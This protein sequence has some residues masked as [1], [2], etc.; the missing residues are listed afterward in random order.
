MEDRALTGYPSVD[1]PWL[2]Y[3]SEEQKNA[4]PPEPM[5]IYACLRQMAESYG[6][7]TAIRFDGMPISYD[8]L[9]A[10]I[11][12]TADALLSA[13]IGEDDIVLAD[14]PTIPQE[15]YLL[16]ACSKIGACI[17]YALP[18]SSPQRLCASANT[19]SS[20]ILFTCDMPPESRAYI[21]SHSCVRQI[22]SLSADRAGDGWAAFLD[23]ADRHAALTRK[24]SRK[25]FYICQTGGSTG[26]PKAVM[27]SNYAF[28]H[29]MFE[30]LTSSGYLDR[31]SSWMPLWPLFSVS[32]AISCCHVPL[33]AGM[34]LILRA[35]PDLDHFDR[36]L[37][38]EKP[39][40]VAIIPAFLDQMLS[41][42]LLRDA[43]LSFLKMI[44]WGGGKCTRELEMSAKAFLT[45]HGAVP[46]ISCGY[47]MS[48][49]SSCISM[50][51][52]PE[53]TVAESVG[54]PQVWTTVGIFEPGTGNELRYDETGEICALSENF[55][56]G[57][58]R[59]DSSHLFRTHADGRIWLHTGDLGRMTEDGILFVQGRMSRSIFT[60]HGHKVYP[61]DLEGLIVSL[62]GIR[63]CAIIP[64]SVP[65]STEY[66]D[67][68][69]CLVLEDGCTPDQVQPLITQAITAACSDVV[70]PG[71]YHLF[72]AFPRTAIGKTDYRALER[73]VQSRLAGQ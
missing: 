28:N 70:L 52:A 32:A 60:K 7:K 13:G 55:M 50:R 41:S 17:S 21:R 31:H 54:I 25:P 43:D 67:V 5:T 65:E 9:F 35:Y 62:P 15:I 38:E 24:D 46:F 53:T 26:R 51:T 72:S 68:A 18:M 33:C 37:L 8:E 66:F 36:L 45:A 16:Y 3:Y 14:L 47:G 22:V 4:I 2:K 63:D 23:A 48:E 58:Y 57:Y 1:R 44:G 34:E 19:F 64:Q 49:N 10:Q 12:R 11:D 69:C 73:D 40:H 59:D 27:I 29:Q 56:S 6:A 42:P 61:D 39:G 20:P 71:S 30:I